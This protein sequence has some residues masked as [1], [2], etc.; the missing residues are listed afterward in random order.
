MFA[1]IQGERKIIQS[2]AY[3]GLEWCTSFMFSVLWVETL[4]PFCKL[5][6]GKFLKLPYS[7]RVWS[8]EL[9][10]L[11]PFCICVDNV[12]LWLEGTLWNVFSG[13]LFVSFMLFHQLDIIQQVWMILPVL[14]D[15]IANFLDG[16]DGKESVWSAVG[17]PG[18][19]PWV[20]KILWKGNGYP[21]QYSCLGKSMNRG[22]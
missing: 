2:F 9:Q 7:S 5:I 4:R 11:F 14:S 16:S 15:L 17:R 8:L 13:N 19:Y 3:R 18:F 22:A 12:T 10:Y 21:L 6:L 1:V 20:R